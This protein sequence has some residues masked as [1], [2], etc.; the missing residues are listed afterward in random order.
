M[1]ISANKTKGIRAAVGY[2]FKSTQLSR[3]HNNANI[4]CLGA[5]LTKKKILKKLYQF[6]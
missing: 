3:Q 5:R 1:A 4:L 6:F 2:N